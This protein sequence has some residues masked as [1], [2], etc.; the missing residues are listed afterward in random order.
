MGWE[1]VRTGWPDTV[2]CSQVDVAEAIGWDAISAINDTGVGVEKDGDGNV[3][4]VRL[5]MRD[6]WWLIVVATPEGFSVGRFRAMVP[7]EWVHG[8]SLGDLSHA[9]LRSASEASYG[10]SGDD[11]G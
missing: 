6:D 4:G 9:V 1:P 10:T 11:D 5:Q 3:V 8:V 7:F 2:P